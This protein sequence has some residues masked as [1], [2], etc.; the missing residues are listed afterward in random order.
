MKKERG[1]MKPEDD[2]EATILGIAAA[3]KRSTPGLNCWK[4]HI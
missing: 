3:Q 4:R 2:R 1:E